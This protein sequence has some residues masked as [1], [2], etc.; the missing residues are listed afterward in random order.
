MKQVVILIAL[1]GVYY[2]LYLFNPVYFWF[3]LAV[4]IVLVVSVFEYDEKSYNP[5]LWL[6]TILGAPLWLVLACC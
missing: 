4:D 6:I 3:L 1:L 2:G 5:F